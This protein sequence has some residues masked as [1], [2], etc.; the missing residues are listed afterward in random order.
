MWWLRVRFRARLIRLQDV[1]QYP[2]GSRLQGV[3]LM[4]VGQSV[5]RW[6]LP[7][8][9]RCYHFADSIYEREHGEH[10]PS[11]NRRHRPFPGAFLGGGALLE[12]VAARNIWARPLIASTATT[13][14]PLPRQLAPSKYVKTP[15]A[16][17]CR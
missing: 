13:G 10:A 6:P 5:F 15:P 1:D 14:A 4:L 7:P 12:P 3:V 11:N 8:S 17:I 16:I 2:E 9:G